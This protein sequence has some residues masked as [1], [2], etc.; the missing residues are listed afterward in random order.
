MRRLG[1][2][3]FGDPEVWRKNLG[4]KTSMRLRLTDDPA[5]PFTEAIGVVQAVR[6]DESGAEA[7]VIVNRRGEQREVRPADVL[8]AKIF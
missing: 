5:H 2:D 3:E 6:T 4:R 1:P 8:A 7:I